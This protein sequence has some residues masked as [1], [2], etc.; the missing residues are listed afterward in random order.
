MPE[1]NFGSRTRAKIVKNKVAP[2]FK[3]AEFDIMYGTGISKD[4]EILDMAVQYDIIH[5]GGSWFSYGD[6]RLGQ[7]RDNVKEIIKNDSELAEEL[8]KKIKDTLA[9]QAEKARQERAEK[10]KANSAKVSAQKPEKKITREEALE[11]INI[12]VEDDED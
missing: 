11:K 4:G 8:E 5:K 10:A 6:R 1:T 7:G 3:S 12:M 9:E 2:P